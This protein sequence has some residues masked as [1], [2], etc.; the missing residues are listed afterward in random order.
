MDVFGEDS[1]A[2]PGWGRRII[3][4]GSS[5]A[6]K[7][8]LAERIAGLI[9]APFIDLDALYWEPGW[10][11]P[12]DEVFRERVSAAISGDRWVVAGNYTR[13]LM[14]TAWPRADTVIWL[15]LPLSI[16]TWRVVRR[17]WRRWRTDELLWGTNRERFWQQFKLWDRDSSLIRF[18]FETHRSRRATFESAMADARWTNIQF[19]RLRSTKAVAALR[20]RLER[21]AHARRGPLPGPRAG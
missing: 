14:P 12:D 6:G 17:S 15:D 7:S 20:E 3:V 19:L 13:H 16:M 21:A 10:T 1:T 5:C 4:V 18:N 8:S 9:D 2:V 11:E